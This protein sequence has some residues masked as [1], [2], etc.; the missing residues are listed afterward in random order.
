MGE[1]SRIKGNRFENTVARA[2]SL[3]VTDGKS[4]Y[5]TCPVEALLFRRKPADNDNIVTDWVGGWD[6]IHSPTL[7]FPFAVECKNDKRLTLRGVATW[8]KAAQGMWAQCRLQAKKLKLEPLLVFKA[9]DH[10]HAH[11][12]LYREMLAPGITSVILIRHP[13]GDLAVLPLPVL[14]ESRLCMA[15]CGPP[16]EPVSLKEQL[17]QMRSV[18]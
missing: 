14:V 5:E 1:Q 12:V 10:R 11:A 2:L 9:A 3:W 8:Q 13:M 4:Y 6:L 17:K 15:R 16:A 7:K 18:G